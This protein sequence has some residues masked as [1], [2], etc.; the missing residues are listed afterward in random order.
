M[1]DKERKL[2]RRSVRTCQI[3]NPDGKAQRIAE[4][5]P[6]ETYASM[7]ASLN[8][9]SKSVRAMMELLKGFCV[10]S[11]STQVLR[12]LAEDRARV[13]LGLGG[14]GL[15][16]ALRELFLPKERRLGAFDIDEILE[17]I[18]WADDLSVI[19]SS[20]AKL[21]PAIHPQQLVV[22]FRDRFMKRG[23]NLLTDYDASEGALY[24]LFY[25]A[26]AS[27]AEAPRLCAIDNFDQCIHPRLASRL[28]QLLS[29]Q[30]VRDGSRQWLLTTHSPLV[31][32][33]LDLRND[34]IRLFA[35]DRT[36]SGVTQVRR[37]QV[38]PEL[39]TDLSKGYS[40]SRLWLMGRLG[41][42][43]EL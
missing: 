38:K 21:S 34:R 24:V 14:G 1:D 8:P 20:E 16:R 35:V 2:L 9:D 30:L 5:V 23:R 33:G 22:E 15:P 18:G 6:T 19:P 37:I 25:L 31:L 43:P 4:P 11:P 17:L 39:L 3:F 27:H 41:G 28:T 10:F 12:G 42:V 7:A 29:E 40:L 32:D 36:D 13:P 26:L